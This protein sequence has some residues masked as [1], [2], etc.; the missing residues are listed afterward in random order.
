MTHTTTPTIPAIST[1][2]LAPEARRQRWLHIARNHPPE[3]LASHLS[4]P[5]SDWVVVTEEGPEID[6]VRRAAYLDDPDD[7]PYWAFALAKLYLDD[8]GEWPLYGMQAEAALLTWESNP[9]PDHL[10]E[11]VRAILA[12]VTPVWPDLKVLS[13]GKE[14]R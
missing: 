10:V 6:R 8:V 13:I 9:D 2:S 1:D 11:T 3:A 14:Q 12:S 4:S 7:L 5:E